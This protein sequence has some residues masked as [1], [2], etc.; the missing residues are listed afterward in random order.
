MSVTLLRAYGGFASGAVV[1]FPDT[2]EATL[3]AQGFATASVVSTMPAV[4][5][6]PDQYVTMFGNVADINQGGL[7][8]P[9]F[10]Q[11]P[12]ILPNLSLGTAALT[13]AGA[14]SVHVAGTLNI[15]EI[16]IPHWNTWK[17][18]AVLNGTVV[19][20][21]NMLVA[22]YGSNGALVA[23]SAVA[24]TL[25]AGASAFQNRDFLTP[26]TLAPGRYFCA[27]QSNGTTATSN[28]FVAANGVNVL[29]TTV[30][31]T[32]G[33]VPATITV[34]TTFTTAVGCVCQ[35]YTV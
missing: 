13:A 7:V 17:G 31:G 30:A 5:G 9:A 27:V 16:F 3:I 33:T 26:V 23:N 1:T 19:G 18:L 15:S 4:L 14:S 21:D 24:G 22:L 8:T 12:S 20:T 35:L 28:K 10:A 34:P 32:F 11:G 6:G 2:T 25:S 29:T